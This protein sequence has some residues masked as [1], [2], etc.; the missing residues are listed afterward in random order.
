MP[1]WDLKA[2]G[3][4]GNGEPDASWLAPARGCNEFSPVSV[5]ASA[6]GQPRSVRAEEEEE[7]EEKPH[8]PG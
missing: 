1:V 6:G 3:E 2:Y 5:A 4:V 7:G 8:G